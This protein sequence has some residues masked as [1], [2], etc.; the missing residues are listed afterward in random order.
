MRNLSIKSKLVGIVLL[1][2]TAALVVG[3]TIVITGDII[4]LRENL[5]NTTRLD[6]GIVG[7]GCIGPLTWGDKPGAR[8][9]LLLL[10]SIPEVVMGK[11]L[12]I[13]G[14]LFADYSIDNREIDQRLEPGK[15]AFSYEGQYLHLTR[16]I[17]LNGVIKGTV[18]LI[19]S[20]ESLDMRIRQRVIS[21]VSLMLGLVLLS[22][23]LALRLQSMISHPILKLA[24]V[25]GTISNKA[26]YS[27]RVQK[28]GSDE[29]GILYDGFNNMLEQ[30]QTNQQM[31]DKAE[32][33]QQRLMAQLAEKNKELEQVIYVTSHDLRSP[34]VN[35]QGFSQELGFS[36]Q[37]LNR[38]LKT[39]DAIPQKLKDRLTTILE[40]DIK[41]SQ[42]Y[43]EASTAKMDG[44][45]SGLLKLSRVDRMG[46]TLTSIDM[47]RLMK[48]II[49][50]FEFQMKEIGAI[51]RVG[52]LAP[53]FANEMQVNQVFS[54]L[55]S[56]ALKYRDPD[57]SLRVTVT[58]REDPEHNHVLYIVEDNAMGIP[59]QHQKRIFEIFHRLNPEES[60]GEGLGLTIV[61]KI[62]SRHHGSITLESEKGK[63]SKF[64]ITLPPAKNPSPQD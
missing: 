12:D 11:I 45:L 38:L 56:N 61:S 13:K 49:K 58:S 22:Y 62:L 4:Q 6:A 35:I 3:F 27:L 44:L 28:A 36:I 7:Q 51:V 32:A 16:P 34:L 33:Q 46:S 23:I 24:D 17:M 64:Y 60:D 21:M 29:I 48:D 26:D 5:V 2:S 47:N 37:E 19:A 54:N 1:V 15:A 8:E 39:I 43:I 14:A 63:G 30:I 57:R 52:D 53:C 18:Y 10:S 55:L 50:S 59:E 31:R 41:E 40:E 9:L 42:D 25:T 20:T